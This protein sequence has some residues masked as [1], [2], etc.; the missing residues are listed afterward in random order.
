M[1][2]FSLDILFLRRQH[3]AAFSL[4]FRPLGNVESN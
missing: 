2:V 1:N 3:A 4:G